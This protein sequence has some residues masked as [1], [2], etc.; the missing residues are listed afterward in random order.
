MMDRG[1]DFSSSPFI[2]ETFSNIFVAFC[3]KSAGYKYIVYFWLLCFAY[4]TFYANTMQF[5]FPPFCR[6][7]KKLLLAYINYVSWWVS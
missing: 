6:V 7:F 5:W 3:G 2:A 1:L 4:V